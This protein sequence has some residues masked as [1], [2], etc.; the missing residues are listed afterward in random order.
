M[1]FRPHNAQSMALAARLLTAVWVA[2]ALVLA[3]AARGQ[4]QSVQTQRSATDQSVDAANP[5]PI[6]DPRVMSDKD[7]KAYAETLRDA[8]ALIDGKHYDDALA[9]L[10]PLIAQHP[11]EP[12]A[13]F[14]KGLALTDAGRTEQA[15]QDFTAL[16]ADFPEL[17]EP[18]N[19]LAVLYAQKGEYEQARDQ[20]ELALKAA[21][22]Y[23]VAHEN[24]ADVYTRLA[25]THYERAAALDRRNKTASAK[26]KLVREVGAA[27]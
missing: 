21:P 4:A 6:V 14:M 16:L 7:R 25:E 3:P 22:D 5:P 24:L 11:R 19:N 18:R 15:I 27:H 12:Q 10:D 17:P 13:R 2:A 20:L 26:L 23:A 1:G 8:R 9:K